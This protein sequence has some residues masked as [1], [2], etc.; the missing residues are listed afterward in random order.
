MWGQVGGGQT[1]RRRLF[2]NRIGPDRL[3]P[4]HDVL[5][6]DRRVAHDDGERY[7]RTGVRR[8]TGGVGRS[9]GVGRRTGGVGRSTGGVVVARTGRRRQLC[10]CLMLLHVVRGRRFRPPGRPPRRIRQAVPAARSLLTPVVHLQQQ[11]RAG[12]LF[13][14]R[15]LLECRRRLGVSGGGGEYGRTTVD[16]GG[17]GGGGPRHF[18]QH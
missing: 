13:P 1:R 5:V 4:G 14:G 10:G 11:V 3:D 9:T 18:R 15:R 7:F 8:R 2:R 16:R 17:R 12:V 6:H